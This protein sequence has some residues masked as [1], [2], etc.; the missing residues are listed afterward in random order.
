MCFVNDFMTVLKGQLIQENIQS[1]NLCTTKPTAEKGGSPGK[2]LY[3]V[4][5]KKWPR[6]D[7]SD[8]KIHTFKNYPDGLR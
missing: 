6:S 3:F 5:G 4:I 8:K 7:V 2:F 1:A